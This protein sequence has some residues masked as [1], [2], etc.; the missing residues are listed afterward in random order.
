MS[1]SQG[2]PYVSQLNIAHVGSKGV[3]LS[4]TDTLLKW[5]RE[6][7]RLGGGASTLQSCS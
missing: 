7:G 3:V 1:L 5:D 2:Y 6:Q 4:P